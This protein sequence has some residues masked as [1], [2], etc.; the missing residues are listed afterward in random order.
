MNFYVYDNWHASKAARIHAADCPRCNHGRGC[1]PRT[2]D[3]GNGRWMGPYETLSQA[4]RM[5]VKTGRTV[6]LH[7]CISN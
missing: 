4:R 5:A 6:E 3:F 1:H 2:H 7:R